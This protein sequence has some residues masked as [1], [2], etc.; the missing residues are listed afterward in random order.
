V[1]ESN[2]SKKQ[3]RKIA[4]SLDAGGCEELVYMFVYPSERVIDVGINR[5]EGDGKGKL[6][7]RDVDYAS[8]YPRPAQLRRCRAA[9][10]P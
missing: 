7:G 4:V 2:R 1:L 9:S 5:I 10:A 3:R 6:V 8:A